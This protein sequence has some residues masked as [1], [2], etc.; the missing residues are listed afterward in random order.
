MKEEIKRRKKRER[1]SRLAH[2][3]DFIFPQEGTDL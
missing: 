3:N 1:N 2:G